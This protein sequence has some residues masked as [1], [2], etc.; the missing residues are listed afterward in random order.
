[1]VD[2]FNNQMKISGL[3]NTEGD[4]VIACQINLDKNYAF[5]E[6]TRFIIYQITRV[7]NIMKFE[8]FVPIKKLPFLHHSAHLHQVVC[9]PR[10]VIG[11]NGVTWSE[12][13]QA[14]K[15][16]SNLLILGRVC[17]VRTSQLK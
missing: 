13:E 6:V 17:N 16:R 8:D 5:I 15:Q 10:N 14:R 7:L 3:T 1:M 12:I 4:S 2:Y 11:W 9:F